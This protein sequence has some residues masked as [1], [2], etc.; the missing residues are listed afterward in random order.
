MTKMNLRHGDRF[1][2]STSHQ[3]AYSLSGRR[4][5]NHVDLNLVLES[6]TLQ[7]PLPT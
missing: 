5:S 4:N 3:V 2:G 6:G 7:I 1:N